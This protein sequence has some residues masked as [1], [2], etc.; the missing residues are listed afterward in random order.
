MKKDKPQFKA[1]NT[2][3]LSLIFYNI[4]GISSIMVVSTAKS[5]LAYFK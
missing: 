1:V 3:R 2:V 5:L 4:N